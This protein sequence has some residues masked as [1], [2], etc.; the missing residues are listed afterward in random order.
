MLVSYVLISSFVLFVILSL[1]QTNIAKDENALE[2]SDRGEAEIPLRKM[3]KHLK[4]QRSKRKKVVK[5]HT[6]LA[7]E[8][9]SE[10]DIDILGVVREI[11]IDNMGRASDMEFGKLINDDEHYVSGRKEVSISRKRRKSNDP[12]S[13]PVLEKKR[14]PLGMDIPTFP[15]LKKSAKGRRKGSGASSRKIK[16]P[17]LQSVVTDVEPIAYLEAKLSKEKDML[18]SMESDNLA[19]CSPKNK[20]FSSRHK[21]KGS[22][23]NSNDLVL[24]ALDHG[25]TVI[26]F[27]RLQ[28]K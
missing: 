6:V 27:S 14:L 5:N 9:N 25:L 26:S 15:Y 20:S 12:L 16:I 21:K 17:S 3:M 1:V 24:E 8:N 23:H 11:N 19:S 18:T 2:N 28:C 13:T 10:K 7:E 22:V 4:S